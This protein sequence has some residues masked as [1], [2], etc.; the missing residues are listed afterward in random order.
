M[1]NGHIKDYSPPPLCLYDFGQW[2]S[3]SNREEKSVIMATCIPHPYKYRKEDIKKES[4]TN[5]A[6][7]Y[8]KAIFYLYFSSSAQEKKKFK[9]M[10]TKQ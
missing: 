3:K 9:F 2:F 4:A 8:F 5:L 6:S 7:K 10:L 1:K